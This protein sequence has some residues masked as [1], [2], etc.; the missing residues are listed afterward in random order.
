MIINVSIEDEEP[1]E[2][3]KGVSALVE[4]IKAINKESEHLFTYQALGIVESTLYEAIK[5]L[6]KNKTK[7]K[8]EK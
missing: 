3:L 8:N 1:V 4:G 7:D 5:K 6:D 2:V